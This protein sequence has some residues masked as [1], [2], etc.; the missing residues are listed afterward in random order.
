MTPSQA[1]AHRDSLPSGMMR[2][3]FVFAALV[4][5]FHIPL[6][7]AGRVVEIDPVLCEGASAMAVALTNRL[8][9]GARCTACQLC[10]T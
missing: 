9:D 4:A 10:V 6:A 3:V 8:D 5:L 1:R 7:G 2:C